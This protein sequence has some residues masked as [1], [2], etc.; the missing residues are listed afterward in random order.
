MGFI[1]TKKLKT[2]CFSNESK[3]IEIKSEAFNGSSLENIILPIKCNK[4][5]KMA[6][7][8]CSHLISVEFL[9]DNLMQINNGSLTKCNKLFIVSFPNAKEVTFQNDLFPEK[10]SFFFKVNAKVSINLIK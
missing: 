4:I 6:F 7:F 10:C 8:D 1:S 2:L 9:C 3:L 5:D